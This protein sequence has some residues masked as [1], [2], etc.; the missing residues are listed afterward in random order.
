[1]RKSFYFIF[2]LIPN[3]I[4]AQNLPSRNDSLKFIDGKMN[5]TGNPV[6][7]GMYQN[8]E[9]PHLHQFKDIKKW[10]SQ[11]N[12]YEAQK[13][14][15]H[16]RLQIFPNANQLISDSADGIFWLGHATFLIR[17]GGMT[18][19]T[20]PV[21]GKAS[22][23]MKRHSALPISVDNLPKIDYIMMSHDHRDHCDKLSL[24]KIVKRNPHVKYFSGLQMDGILNK[25]LKGA[26]GQVAG[27]YQQYS[28]E[29]HLFKLWFLPT[30][31]WGKRW[32][33]DTNKRLWGSFV[34]EIDGL[35]I[36]FGGDSG[37]GSHYKEIAQL[38]PKIDIAILGIGAFEPE[39]F[40]ETNHSSPEKAFQAFVDLKANYMVPM[41]Y[42]TFDLSDEPVCLPGQL[43]AEIAIKNEKTQQVLIPM[44]GQNIF[45]MLK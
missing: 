44:L 14:S 26:Q 45:N 18:F 41:H 3:I 38:F 2:I 35:V 30:R 43:L 10:K 6:K 19:I 5:W 37:Y 13:K 17:I 16:T 15:D 25:F 20:D 34:L 4:M 8:H 29:G 32:F 40:M 23:L 24:K 36:Y 33:T 1:M 39:W 11:K 31:H 22:G 42:G 21:L 9:F 27:W 7:N 28:L 12:P